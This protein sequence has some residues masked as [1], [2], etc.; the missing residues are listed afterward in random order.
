MDENVLK[1]FTVFLK[2]KYKGIVQ[3]LRLE[4]DKELECPFIYL[5]TIKIRKPLRCQGYGS[6]VL[7]EIIK[8]ADMNDLEIRLYA[9]N[10]LGSDLNRL[11]DFYIRYGFE[12]IKNDCGKFVR[13]S[14]KTL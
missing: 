9:T 14:K 4:Y 10:I 2:K 12:L 3:E 13:K 1:E 8:F 6:T 7:Q 11:Y 5:H